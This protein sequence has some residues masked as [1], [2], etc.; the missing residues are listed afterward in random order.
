MRRYGWIAALL[1]SFT[2]LTAQEYEAELEKTRKFIEEERFAAAIDELKAL[3]ERLQSRIADELIAA[4]PGPLDDWRRSD[5]VFQQVGM[6]VYGGGLSL[7]AQYTGDGKNKVEIQI[8]TKSPMVEGL[9]V[10]LQSN[11]FSSP[12]QETVDIAGYQCL[13]QLNSSSRQGDL[14]MILG[15]ETLA[16][17]TARDF[18]DS[19]R[20][21]TALLDYAG[22]IVASAIPRITGRK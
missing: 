18:S 4:F 21:R 10:L 6:S 17:V 3:I 20:M 8:I 13:V 15:T 2:I 19:T 22:A 16:T 12:D 5:V 9:A 1:F 11:D 7:T 14:K